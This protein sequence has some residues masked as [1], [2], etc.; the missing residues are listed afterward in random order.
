MTAE[1]LNRLWLLATVL[2]ILIIISTLMVVLFKRDNGQ[3]L[4]ISTPQNPQYSGQVYIDGAVTNSGAF[5]F[6]PDDSVGSLI[7]ASGGVQ[8]DADLAAVQLHVPSTTIRPDFQKIDINRADSW[9][10][11]A[12]PGIGEIKA[13]AILDYR[14]Q[15][16]HFDNIEQ[17]TEVPGIS[18]SVFDKIKEYVTT[19]DR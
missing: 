19:D 10:L 9:L 12:L 4:S 11:Q 17:L 1:K 8:A 16:G 2:L 3:P 14:K 6:G 5:A 15:I 7:K 18:S 13:Q